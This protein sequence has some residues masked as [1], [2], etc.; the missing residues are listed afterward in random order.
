MYTTQSLS[1]SN[2]TASIS[3]SAFIVFTSFGDAIFFDEKKYSPSEAIA[4]EFILSRYFT[5]ATMEET[6]S[7]SKPPTTLLGIFLPI[8]EKS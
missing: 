4:T 1:P 8:S 2:A 5:L 7:S 3:L 6:N